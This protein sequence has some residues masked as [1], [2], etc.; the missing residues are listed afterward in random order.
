MATKDLAGCKLWDSVDDD[1]MIL[2]AECKQLASTRQH[3]MTFSGGIWD[4]TSGDRSFPCLR[5]TENCWPLTN[6]S[7]GSNPFSKVAQRLVNKS[8]EY[9]AP[10][11]RP[12]AGRASV[13]STVSAT[14]ASRLFLASSSSFFAA[15]SAG[16]FTAHLARWR[17]FFSASSSLAFALALRAA[18]PPSTSR[19]GLELRPAGQFRPGTDHVAEPCHGGISGDLRLLIPGAT[20]NPHTE[21]GALR[22]WKFGFRTLKASGLGVR[23]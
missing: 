12:A 11:P 14:L 21:L 20:R 19:S 18:F 23:V 5:T 7:L 2:S 17:L 13:C 16:H 9:A 10:L 4:L 15:T 22:T 3:G 6:M 8:L 1:P